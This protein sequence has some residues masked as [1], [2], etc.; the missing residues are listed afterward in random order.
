[1]AKSKFMNLSLE[2]KVQHLY[3]HANF[4]AD[5]RYYKYKIN[6]FILNGNYFEVFINHKDVQ[7]TKIVPLDYGSSRLRFYLDQIKL[8][9]W[10]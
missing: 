1:M 5:I 10:K 4:V 9:K 7:I 8:P 3:E 6:L 2:D